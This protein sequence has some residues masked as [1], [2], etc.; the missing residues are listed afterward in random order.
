MRGTPVRQSK[1][2]E[3]GDLLD[4]LLRL[5]PED[6]SIQLLIGRRLCSPAMSVSHP[7]YTL[8]AHALQFIIAIPLAASGWDC[9]VVISK[10]QTQPFRPVSCTPLYVWII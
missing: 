6:C 8:A 9:P 2:G 10:V 7:S 1:E 5:L 4:R 3:G